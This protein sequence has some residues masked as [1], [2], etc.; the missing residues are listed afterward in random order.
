[1]NIMKKTFQDLVCRQISCLLACMTILS[2]M[3][4]CGTSNDE[5][6]VDVGD[7]VS[8]ET[9]VPE[10]LPARWSHLFAF[11]S[12]SVG[13]A[14]TNILRADKYVISKTTDRG[15]TWERQYSA[16]G[17]CIVLKPYEDKVYYSSERRMD[18]SVVFKSEI[19]FIDNGRRKKILS[20]I[21]GR[22]YSMNVFNDSTLTYTQDVS[23]Q[24]EYWGV[25]ELSDSTY[26]STDAGKTWKALYTDLKQATVFGYDSLNV[27]IT[28]YFGAPPAK[29]DCCWVV[30]DINTGSRKIY[31]TWYVFTAFVDDGLLMKD[32]KFY[33][34]DDD[35][36]HIS[37]YYWNGDGF[38]NSHGSYSAW[39]FAKSGETALAYATQFPGKKNREDCIFYSTDGGYIWRAFSIGHGLIRPGRYQ[40]SAAKIPS[41]AGLSVIYQDHSDSLRI[42]N[43]LPIQ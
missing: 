24:K 5:L 27:Y 21:K 37:T 22:V 35:M 2:V 17:K 42:I 14:A 29:R 18:S 1:M 4:G 16:R 12:D 31:K 10:G 33:R 9:F 3:N 6:N 25:Y 30:S 20:D 40:S 41:E 19:G 34:C 28:A 43:V 15:R 38:M 8:V 26:L 11:T 32:S 36:K 23:I 39:Y 7:N 13:Y